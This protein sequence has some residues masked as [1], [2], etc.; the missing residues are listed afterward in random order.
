MLMPSE[1][2]KEPYFERQPPEEGLS[3]IVRILF[4]GAGVSIVGGV[5]TLF[6]LMFEMDVKQKLAEM[7]K[8]YAIVERR[9]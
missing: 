5:W 2:W 4:I 7:Q 1:G 6:I 9:W 8:P 3:L